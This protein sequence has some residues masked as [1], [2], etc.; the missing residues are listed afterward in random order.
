[1]RKIIHKI[2]KNIINLTAILISGTGL[3]T[4]LTKFN[5]PELNASFFGEN[6]FAIKKGIVE[7][8]MTWIF[9]SLALFGL[10]LRAYVEISENKIN[11]R[12]HAAG[13]YYK[14][15]C[16]GIIIMFFVVIALTKV[17]NGIARLWWQPVIVD[18][19]KELFQM[20]CAI[21]KNNGWRDD[22]LAIKDKI[23]N[24]EKYKDANWEKVEGYLSQIEKLLDIQVNKKSALPERIEK[25][26]KY[27]GS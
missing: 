12:L 17:G 13:F 5:V 18:K 7:N 8:T 9:S 16:T 24:P 15:L 2:D 20:A 26:K 1:M 4:V 25:L 3:F 6:P 23:N 27:F 11:K 22:Q 14:F 10:L 19:Q 21:V